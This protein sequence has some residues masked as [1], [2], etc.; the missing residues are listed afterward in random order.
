MHPG[1]FFFSVYFFAKLPPFVLQDLFHDVSK[2]SLIKI[3]LMIHHVY[4]IWLTKW[5]KPCYF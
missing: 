3:M 2:A 4:L 5:P 1:H